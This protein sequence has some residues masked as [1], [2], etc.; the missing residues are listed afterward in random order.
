MDLDLHIT[1]PA[2]ESLEPFFDWNRF[3][4]T[5]G[6]KNDLE[7]P[8]A[9]KL[10]KDVLD[11]LQKRVVKPRLIYKLFPCVRRG[12]DLDILDKQ[13]HEKIGE[14]HTLR[15]QIKRHDGKPMYALC[16]F[17]DPHASYVGMFVTTAGR[18]VDRYVEVLRHKQDDYQV[19]IARTVSDLVAEALSC[20][21]ESLFLD[22]YD[23]RP[24]RCIRPAP[25]YP[26]QVD[27]SEKFEI[28]RLLNVTKN[29]GVSL[30]EHAMMQPVSSVCALFFAHMEAHYFSLGKIGLDQATDYAHRKGWSEEEMRFW[31]APVLTK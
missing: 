11:F 1:H 21:S 2:V 27:H 22:L 7:N 5:W 30:T 6:M 24:T 25:G 31:L 23:E 18:E 14:L 16:D 10:K 19:M 28:F 4:S 17:V 29:I 12:H 9:I 15:Q 13:T 26:T 3:F 20:Y 8:E